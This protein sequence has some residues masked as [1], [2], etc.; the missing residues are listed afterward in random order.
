VEQITAKK[1]PEN[2]LKTE[3]ITACRSWNQYTFTRLIVSRAASEF[4]IS[5]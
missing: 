1:L 4:A 2:C 3:E 5:R